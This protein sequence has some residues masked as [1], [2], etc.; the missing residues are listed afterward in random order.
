MS[1]VQA[2]P[3]GFAAP[4]AMTALSICVSNILVGSYRRCSASCVAKLGCKL[5]MG[6]AACSKTRGQLFPQLGLVLSACLHGQ[7]GRQHGMSRES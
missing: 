7:Q 1:F 4:F 6:Q 5:L 3:P 2:G